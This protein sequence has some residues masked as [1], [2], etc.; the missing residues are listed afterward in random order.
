M[1]FES[2]RLS[3]KKVDL[4]KRFSIVLNRIF[5]LANKKRLLKNVPFHPTES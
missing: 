5:V 1:F 2:D 3:L 4:E